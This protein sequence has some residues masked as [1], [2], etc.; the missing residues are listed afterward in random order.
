MSRTF[1]SKAVANFSVQTTLSLL[2]LVKISQLI[3]TL[4]F[5]FVRALLADFVSIYLPDI[6]I[7]ND[8]KRVAAKDNSLE[9]GVNAV[10]AYI[11]STL[12]LTPVLI[13]SIGHC[14]NVAQVR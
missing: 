1:Q 14:L 5:I 6:S 8:V 2:N 13:S 11:K 12:I 9:I 3:I 4:R 10:G 7:F